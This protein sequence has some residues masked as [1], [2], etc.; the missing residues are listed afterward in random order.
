LRKKRNDSQKH[1]E[2][3]K[4]RILQELLQ[5]DA[6][7]SKEENIELSQ[8]EANFASSERISA[9]Q[10]SISVLQARIDYSQNFEFVQQNSQRN[11]NASET[12]YRAV[13]ISM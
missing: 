9:S 7:F 3:K 13:Y 1:I 2:Q 12:A 8:H 6:V 5:K 11:R 4:I 10:K